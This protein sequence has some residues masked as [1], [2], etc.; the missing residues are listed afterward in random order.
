MDTSVLTDMLPVLGALAIRVVMAGVVLLVGWVLAKWIA[1]L[2]LK[3]LR[4]TQLDNRLAKSVSGKQPLSL[5]STI[6][7]LIFYLLMLFVLV[8]VFE[9]LGLT[10]ITQPLN[11]F[12]GNVFAYLPRLVSA[13][14][15]I[16][17]A[18]VIATVLRGLTHKVLEG[19]EVD[20]RLGPDEEI[21]KASISKTLADAVYWLVWLVFLLPILQAFGFESL[22]VP[23]LEMF[24]KAMEYLPNVIGAA[25]V[26]LVGWFV[27]RI[28]QRIVT[29]FLAAVGADKFSDR[30]GL[31]KMLGK[32]NLSGI[33]GYIV[34]LLILLPV[35]MTSLEALGIESLTIPLTSM[36]NRVFEAIPAIISAAII[37]FI[38]YV[39]GKLLGE[40][41][42]TLLEGLGFD[43]VMV[44]LGL[45]RSEK[46]WKVTPSRMV[47]YLVLFAVMMLAAVSAVSLLNM[48]ALSLLVT[49]FVSF[50]WHIVLGMLIFGLGLWLANVMVA[51]VNDTDWPNKK[52]LTTVVRIAIIAL[53]TAMALKQMGLADSIINMAFGLTLG[54]TALAAAL[55]FG[56]GGREVAARELDNWVNSIHK[57]E[58]KG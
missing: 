13:G 58:D 49:Q 24:N 53:T 50:F 11:V 35:L 48:P 2:V 17:V 3:L 29:S 6:A 21:D 23:L 28:V 41:V 8:A 14:I 39:G 51:F 7:S 44:K 5:E 57:D 47:G 55:A 15:L 45:S 33:L 27:A 31:G 19:F 25:F 26:L 16:V 34:F 54:A 46:S 30:V 43:N 12:L 40:M 4:K 9:I 18:W 36:L 42:A 38:S 32:Q 56:L 37:L 10:L 20:K 52:M 22:V 1:K